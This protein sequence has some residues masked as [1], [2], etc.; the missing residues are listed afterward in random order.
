MM[1]EFDLCLDPS[2][3]L[4]TPRRGATIAQRARARFSTDAEETQPIPGKEDASSTNELA[5]VSSQILLLL[6]G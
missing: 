4:G 2:N 3:S 1:I 6:P 5:T